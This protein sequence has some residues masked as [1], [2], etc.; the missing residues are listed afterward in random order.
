MSENSSRLTLSGPLVMSTIGVL[1]PQGSTAATSGDLIVDFSAT[2]D[3]DSSALALLMQWR[4]A[5][6]AAGHQ[7][8][9]EQVPHNLQVLA[10]LY[11][12]SF[13]LSN[14]TPAH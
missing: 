9:F 7:L 14:G 2:T 6:E 13:L 4:R 11:G 3:I 1:L 5:A 12:V 8:T 10:D